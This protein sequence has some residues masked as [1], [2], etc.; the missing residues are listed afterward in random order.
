M[1]RRSVILGMSLLVAAAL[2]AAA[3]QV[4]LA[5]SRR[6][7]LE[8]EAPGYSARTP[9]GAE[10]VVAGLGGFRGLIAEVVW[11]R[12]DRLQDSGNYVELAQLSAWLT[13]LEPRTPEVWS[14]AAWNL[15]YNI[16]AM[17]STPADRWRWV[18]AG[19]KL[20]RD[21]G[22]RINPNDPAL[23]RELAWMFLAKIGG[24]VD[25]AHA[26]Y[27]ARWRTAVESARMTGNWSPLAMETNRMAAVDADYGR[28]DWTRP[29]ASAIYWAAKGLPHARGTARAALR[30]I[31]YEAL[32][33]EA[34][35]E[36]GFAPRALTELETAY[37]E[38]P[39]RG[40]AQVIAGFRRHCGL[41]N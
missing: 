27:E 18:E 36:P 17:M 25:D 10:L 28:Q 13:F 8:A 21:D 7:R 2:G 38:T 19:L 1:M 37:R 11:F 23:H 4:F 34:S 6:A 41:G 33:M 39:S 9:P 3:S 31:L 35:T 40:L 24:P 16:S 15:A 32:M 20:L 22:L 26:F 14:Y 5:R 29:V 30:Q 12:A